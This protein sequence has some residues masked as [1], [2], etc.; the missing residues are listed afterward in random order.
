MLDRASG[1]ITVELNADWISKFELFVTAQE[2]RGKRRRVD[3]P[4]PDGD[5]EEAA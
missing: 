3:E 1:K 5:E 2:P 4:Q